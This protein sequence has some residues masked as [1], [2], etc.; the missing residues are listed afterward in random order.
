MCKTFRSIQQ[1]LA[2]TVTGIVIAQDI[3]PG[4]WKY[5]FS[6]DLL[7]ILHRAHKCQCQNCASNLNGFY[8]LHCGHSDIYIP[9][10][11]HKHTCEYARCAVNVI[12]I[13]IW[14]NTKYV[15]RS[16]EKGMM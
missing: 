16:T 1:I 6:S 13:L 14:S 10:L 5:C 12:V 11:L 15:Q 7:P 9:N 3:S 8:F 2:I 4:V